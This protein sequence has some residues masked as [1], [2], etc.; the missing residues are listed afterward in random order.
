[1]DV[2]AMELGDLVDWLEWDWFWTIDAEWGQL[3]L[4]DLGLRLAAATFLGGLIGLEREQRERA[5]GLRTPW[6]RWA[7]PCSRSFPST[8]FPCCRVARERSTRAGSPPR[9]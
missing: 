4:W 7:R 1:M 8:G 3:A 2:E 5:A 9:S 6:F